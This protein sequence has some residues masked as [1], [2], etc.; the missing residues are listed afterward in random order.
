MN[1]KP[2]RC[3]PL[4]LALLTLAFVLQAW[5]PP[6]YMLAPARAGVPTLVICPGSVD[7]HS[8]KTPASA[9]CPFAALAEPGLLPVPP[10]VFAEPPV[11]VPAGIARPDPLLFPPPFVAPH[12]PARGPPAIG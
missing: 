6:G 3:R 5:I 2:G 8:K 12:P 11:P 10:I 9:P 1:A 4:A 7:H